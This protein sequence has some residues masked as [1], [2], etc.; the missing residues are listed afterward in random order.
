MDFLPSPPPRGAGAPGGLRPRGGSDK[1]A[2]VENSLCILCLFAR[3][4]DILEEGLGIRRLA[5]FEDG[6]G[7]G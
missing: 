3:L 2:D 4:E 5:G 6:G 7:K 1:L